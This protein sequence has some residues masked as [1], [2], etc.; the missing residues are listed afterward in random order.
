[1]KRITV[2]NFRKIKGEWDIKLSPVTFFV[3]T[4]NSGKSSVLKS[5]MLLDDYGNS[6]DHFTLKFNKEHSNNHKIDSYSNAI[7]RFNLSEKNFDIEFK[8]E[9]ELYAIEFCFFP[10]EYVGEKFEKGKLKSLKFNSNI[11]NSF[12]SINHISANEYQV[13]LD[14]NFYYKTR[15][16][17]EIFE[18]LQSYESI[19]FVTQSNIN[20]KNEYL[21]ENSNL[22]FRESLSIKNEI[23]DLNKLLSK[24]KTNINQLNSRIS[25]ENHILQPKINLTEFDSIKTIDK[26]LLRIL[27][28]YISENNSKNGYVNEKS[29]MQKITF[30]LESISDSLKLNL[31]HLTPNRNIQTRLYVNSN[32]TNDIHNIINDY[33]EY[34]ILKNS[35]ADEFLKY[36]MA[37]FDIGE[38]YKISPL[39]GLATIIEINEVSNND[40]SWINL[41]DKG[42][43]AGQ[44]FSI[45]LRIATSINKIEL[46]NNRKFKSKAT[47]FVLKEK[48]IFL[49]EEPEANLHP[50]F[51]SL[52]AEMFYQAAI[53][54]G[55]QFIIETHSEYMIRSSQLI[56]LK[57]INKDTDIFSVYYFDESGP[58]EMKYR[59]DGSF[60]KSFGEGFLD[61]VDDIAL[62]IF[63]KNNKQ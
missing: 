48:P 53:T 6:N 8:I 40:N 41:V 37:K 12:L 11:D 32:K 39:H 58:Y 59:N 60:N 9:N 63:L 29:E 5:L 47:Y 52:L 44:I 46:Q 54:F 13:E 61:V 51:Q 34:P 18:D 35:K 45:L 28:F 16:N 25:R 26:V 19:L 33:Y 31:S 24:I 15:V 10:Y 27:S 57:Q 42:F 62:E 3:G 20:L 23:K 7:N 1:M 14:T 17:D 4:N 2:K 30:M 21:K 22:N 56:H 55:L 36:W 43:G 38:D 50:K 49:I